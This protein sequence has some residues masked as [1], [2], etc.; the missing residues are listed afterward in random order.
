MPAQQIQK[1]TLYP[2]LRAGM[3]DW[4][5]YVTTMR[6]SEV[7]QMI[8]YAHEI[9]SNQSLNQLIQRRLNESRGKKI[10]SY[11]LREKQRFFNSIVVGVYGGDPSWY[12]F[13]EIVPERPD[14]LSLPTGAENSFGFLG[15]T[16]KENLFALDGQHRLSGIKQAIKKDATEIGDDQI[17]VIFVGHHKGKEG[18]Q[19][20][21]RLFTTLNKT[22]KPVLKGDIIALDED[23]IMAICVR[24][25]LDQCPFFKRGQVA[26]RLQNS[27]PPSDKSSWTTITMMYDILTVIFR[28]IFPQYFEVSKTLEEMKHERPSD[29]AIDEY[30]EFA[31]QYF[32][33][34][35]NAFSSVE[36][37]FESRTPANA[38]KKHR[39][40]GGGS[41]LFRPLGQRMFAQLVA[42]LSKS[43][44]LEDIFEWLSWLPTLLDQ[45]PYADV[46]WDT[47]TR[48]MTSSK[49]DAAIVRDVLLHMLGEDRRAPEDLR[50][51]YAQYLGEENAKLPELVVESNK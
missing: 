11:L 24:R 10:S 19:R 14:E 47:G 15:F 33:L 22:A 13:A 31:V 29:D 39:S 1:A 3:G 12:D 26:M 41:V 36:E 45:P 16:G 28:H 42:E 46:I 27:L 21:R 7:A 5:Y 40:V 8:D 48:K 30:Y 6:L 4:I 34:L 51:K 9:H 23:D 49:T 25:L 35:A 2:S 20:T 38:V 43:Y 50:K 44:D 18:L 32:Q 17:T 37:V